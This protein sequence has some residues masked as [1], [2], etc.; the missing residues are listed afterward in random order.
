MKRGIAFAALVLVGCASAVPGPPR[1]L[2][3]WDGARERALQTAA[4]GS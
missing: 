2:R 4:W 3:E 1:R